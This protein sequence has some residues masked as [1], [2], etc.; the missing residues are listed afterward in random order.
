MAVGIYRPLDDA[1]RIAFT[2]LVRWIHE[3]Y[4]LSEMDDDEL[5]SK[6]AEIHL[7]EMVDRT[8]SSSPKSTRNSCLLQP[9]ATSSDQPVAD[10]DLVSAA[11]IS[12][13]RFIATATRPSA[14]ST[15]SRGSS[16][17][18]SWIAP[19]RTPS[20]LRAKRAAPH[21]VKA[22]APED[23][24]SF[25]AWTGSAVP[26]SVSPPTVSALPRVFAAIAVS[27]LDAAAR[28]AVS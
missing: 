7:D 21:A 17:K 23:G 24:P 27:A 18:L 25:E 11:N 12:A 4:G 15:A 26:V 10:D 1:L 19:N 13:K 22:F 14:C 5:L 6:I 20:L 16:T 9:H 2:E 3:R 8:T 28:L